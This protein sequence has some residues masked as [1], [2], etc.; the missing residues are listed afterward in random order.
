M[1]GSDTLPYGLLALNLLL[2]V[3]RIWKNVKKCRSACC[4]IENVV[5]EEGDDDSV[6]NK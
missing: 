1:D 6:K 4:D 2:V 5:E 3:E